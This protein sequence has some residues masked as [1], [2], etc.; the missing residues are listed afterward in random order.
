M[1]I[2]LKSIRGQGDPIPINIKLSKELQRCLN[3]GLLSEHLIVEPDAEPDPPP[4][5]ARPQTPARFIQEIFKILQVMNISTHICQR[6][7]PDDKRWQQMHSAINKTITAIDTL[8]KRRRISVLLSVVLLGMMRAQ[9][10]TIWA[11][12]LPLPKGAKIVTSMDFDRESLVSE[13]DTGELV[14]APDPMATPPLPPLRQINKLP[15]LPGIRRLERKI[16]KIFLK[17]RGGR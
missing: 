5:G 2:Y 14:V 6:R 13:K 10:Y 7:E 4:Q 12:P 8:D 9:I 3:D 11:Q 15:R 1:K 16:K 17:L